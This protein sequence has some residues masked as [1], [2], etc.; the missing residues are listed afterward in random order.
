MA[1]AG[2]GAGGIDGGGGGA[3]AGSDGAAGDGA[4]GA[5]GASG[6]LVT[7]SR[8]FTGTATLL[9]NGPSCTEEAGATGDRWCAFV[10]FTDATMSA[11]SL[12]VVNVSRVAA[13][14]E[15]TC[16]PA[17]GAADAELP[18]ADGR[19][20]AATPGRPTLHGTF[21]QGDT[22]VYYD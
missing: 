2:P 19:R 7:G 10:T 17:G 14:V 5:A 16:G 20:W 1:N 11:R 22:L 3:A 13:G 6:G 15:V 9:F 18:V 12:Y 21:F 4:D 8:V